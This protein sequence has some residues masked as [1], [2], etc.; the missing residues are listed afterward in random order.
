MFK[1]ENAE[2]PFYVK[3]T[4]ILVSIIAIVYISVVIKDVLSPLLFGL[5]FSILLLPVADFFEN[6]LR[7][8]RSGAA[9]I[10]VLLLLL[11]IVAV[12]SLL[13]SQINN[14]AQDLPLLQE[15]VNT[16]LHGI[17][18]WISTKTHI[19]I[20][21]QM[22]YIQTATTNI[23]EA[24]PSMIGS[25]FLSLSSILLFLVFVIL[26]TF[27][28]LLYRRRLLK[29][30][31]DIFD[32][33]YTTTV[34]DI[35]STSQNIIRKYVVG[36][37]L[38]MSTVAAV[39]CTVFL[40]LG[41]KY[42]ILLGLITAI[43]NVVPY[44]GIFSALLLNVLITFATTAVAGKVILVIITVV[45]MHLVDSNILLPVIVG[46]KVK[47]NAFITLLGVV[48]GEMAW[49]ISG[50]FLSIPVIAILKIIFDRIE[51]LRP[52]GHLLGDEKL[53]RKKIIVRDE[54]KPAD[55]ATAV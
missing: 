35:V 27:F 17:Q 31:V 23:K 1:S 42:A 16:S 19:N 55:E 10:S 30:L 47:I 38:Q 46:S 39:C 45:V 53:V 54:T 51:T 24:S 13:G 11:S 49:G 14:L 4:M 2:T 29:F 37:F 36:L 40:M 9:A 7:F 5:L 44:I 32:R 50:M 21:K 28:M 33:E 8:S 43:F 22:A 20:D 25:T 48:L 34:Y 15:Q 26:D 3:L 6:R 18:Q 12:M 52:W 41:I